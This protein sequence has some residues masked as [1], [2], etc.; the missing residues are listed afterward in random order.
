MANRRLITRRTVLKAAGAS[1]L[2]ALA[3]PALGAASETAPRRPNIV[4]IVADDMGFSDLGCYGGEIETP[5]LDGLARG[6][7][8]FTQFYSN[9][10]CSPTR[11]SLLTGLYCEQ[12]GI[13]VGPRRIS[14]CVMIPEVLKAAG[15]RSYAAGK[16][17]VYG[18]PMDWGFD[19][20][21]GCLGG[22]HNYFNPGLQRPGEPEPYRKRG[23]LREFADDRQSIQP[24]TPPEGW[25]ATD[26]YTDRAIGYLEEHHCLHPDRPFLLY[27]AYNAPHL[28]LHA[29]PEDIEKY[30]GRYMEG[31]RALR[32]ERYRRQVED[33]IIDPRWELSPQQGGDWRA[34]EDKELEDLK[35]ATYAAMVHC[36]DRNV[37][38]L[39]QQVRRMGAEQDTLVLFFSDNGANSY[40]PEKTPGILPGPLHSYWGY[41]TP[42][43]NMSNTPFKRY[44]HYDMEGGIATPLIAYWPAAVEPGSMNRQPGHVIDLMPTCMDLT[45]VE[46]PENYRGWRVLPTEGRSLVP[47]LRGRRREGHEALYWGFGLDARWP[48]REVQR[49]VREGRWK[50]YHDASRGQEPRLFDLEADRT[51]VHDLSGRHPD[52]TRELLAKWH[53]WADRCDADAGV[54][55]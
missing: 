51:E 27:L 30:R 17:H 18:H 52:R 41:G 32:E 34:E 46:Y 55:G 54:R 10:K 21:F 48:D 14:N 44:K 42:W 4:L 20:Y 38:R 6:G 25:Y 11:N 12:L 23:R 19:H 45:G 13:H 35:M 22:G 43:A 28:P 9:A 5:V 2:G 37:G 39:M 40:G 36:M 16:W 24:F 33:G 29:W 53:A 26:A 3:A 47:S 7:M 49:V 1:A 8:R 31:W 50:L 15:Y